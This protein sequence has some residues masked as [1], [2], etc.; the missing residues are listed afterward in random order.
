MKHESSSSSHKHHKNFTPL[1]KYRKN[2][3]IKL[4]F[5]GIAA[6]VVAVFLFFYIFWGLPS[7]YSLKDYKAIPLSTHI[8]DRKGRLLYEIFNEQNRTPIKL[9]DLPPYVSQ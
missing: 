7:P 1:K 3:D 9:K 4:F 8:L 5:A 6:G 2:L